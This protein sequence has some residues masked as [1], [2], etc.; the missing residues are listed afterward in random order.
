MIVLLV[1]A[2]RSIPLYKGF[3]VK[4]VI[5]Q[6]VKALLL[7]VIGMVVV[8]VS[9][10]WLGI[11]RH[12]RI[13][14]GF[15]HLDWVFQPH[16]P[17]WYRHMRN[18]FWLTLGLALCLWS[19]VSLFQGVVLYKNYSLGQRSMTGEGESEGVLDS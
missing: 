19:L 16:L 17:Y 8:Y 1:V 14:W 15:L 9:L 5:I 13:D 4:S 18:L 10:V 12:G 3:F 7:A 6:S 2:V 11:R